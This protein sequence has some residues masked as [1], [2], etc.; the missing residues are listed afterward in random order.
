[1][2]LI[3]KKRH[4]VVSIR[5]WGDQSAR[6]HMGRWLL[7][8]ELTHTEARWRDSVGEYLS[9]NWDCVFLR[10]DKESWRGFLYHGRELVMRWWKPAPFD[11]ATAAGPTPM[12]QKD[13]QR[14]R[15]VRRTVKSYNQEATF[16]HPKGLINYASIDQMKKPYRHFHYSIFNT[17]QSRRFWHTTKCVVT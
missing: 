13:G 10:S 7:R 5:W 11:T 4:T 1:M 2:Q 16:I 6:G 17:G 3:L 9:L 14:G 8:C 15:V 12:V